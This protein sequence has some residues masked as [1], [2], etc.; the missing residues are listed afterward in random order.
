MSF[1]L[2][3][4][5]LRSAFIRFWTF[6]PSS[7]RLL[8]EPGLPPAEV[9]CCGQGRCDRASQTGFSCVIENQVLAN[10][11]R[12]VVQHVAAL[13]DCVERWR[14]GQTIIAFWRVQAGGSG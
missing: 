8:A 5:L 13:D 7:F 9:E 10:F 6:S 3:P 4:R 12:E 11:Q 2:L 14:R 1:V